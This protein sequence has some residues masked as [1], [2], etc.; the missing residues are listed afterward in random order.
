MTFSIPDFLASLIERPVAVLGGG[1][2][3]QG[4]AELLEAIGAD[5][6]IYDE[7]GG[8]AKNFSLTEAR[9]HKLVVFSPGFIPAHPWLATARAVGCVCLSELDFGWLFWRGPVLAITGTNGKTTL[10]EFLTQALKDAGRA[11]VAVGN[12]GFPLTRAAARFSGADITAV[13]EVSSFQSERLEH[14]RAN[15]TIW[16][17]LAE[18]HLER[19]A[20]MEGYFLAKWRLVE[21][22]T[23]G[24]VFA[25]SSVQFFA[26]KFGKELPNTASV[27]SEE[28]PEDVHLK[29]TIFAQYPQREN[30]I[31]AAT[32]WRF[33]GF[34]RESLYQTAKSFKLGRHRLSRVGERRGVVFWNDSKATNFHA[35]EAALTTF[36]SPVLWVGGGKAKGGDIESFVQRIASKVRHAFL[37]GDT[38]DIL[39]KCFAA[40]RVPFTLCATLS[41]AVHQAFFHAKAGD[42]I[43]L[44]PGFA[45][46]GLFRNY[47]DR[48]NQFE[49]IVNNL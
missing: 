25:G 4:A 15:A 45:S 39:A 49:T 35:V 23:P 18:D 41:E 42:H 32:W 44:S 40:A 3:G 31:L 21:R 24:A 38:K 14:F 36:S 1:V 9:E 47:E 46:F 2:S 37:I 26:N 43:L 13:C 20:G 19:H 30:F 27:P 7:T 34:T 5:S 28:Q 33:A 8:A 16:T 22:T 11:A 48:G 12:I 29:G 17:N 10:T 6:V